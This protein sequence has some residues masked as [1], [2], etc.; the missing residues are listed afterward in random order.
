VV[1]T[2]AKSAYLGFGQGSSQLLKRVID[3]SARSSQQV[4]RPFELHVSLTPI[5]EFAAAMENDPV[6]K[7]L[8]DSIKRSAGKDHIRIAQK[9][10]ERGVS[11]RL[12]VEEGVLQLIGAAV[13]ARN[14]PGNQ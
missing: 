2:G 3:D 13:K 7:V 5:L 4:V 1:G 8:A 9:P 11:T 12:E 6:V 10:V 14:N